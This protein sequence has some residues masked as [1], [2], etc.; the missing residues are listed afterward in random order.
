MTSAERMAK[1]L[2]LLQR[3]V[4]GESLTD[5]GNEL[6]ITKQA[7]SR[8]FQRFLGDEEYAIVSAQIRTRL[9]A[10]E[11]GTRTSLFE[12]YNQTAAILWTDEQM[13]E[14]LR[15]FQRTYG[16]P[17]TISRIAKLPPKD[18]HRV[19]TPPIYYRRFGTWIEACRRAGVTNGKPSRTN[20]KRRWNEDEIVELLIPFA[21]HY[22][23]RGLRPTSYRYTEWHARW[24]DV[25]PSLATIRNR[26]LWNRFMGI[27]LTRLREEQGE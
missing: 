7:V 24:A 6:G 26:G 4:N 15:W 8:R 20:Y 12:P 16:P 13:L 27:V 9:H 25:T 14:A 19:P 5:L 23:E 1:T 3:H 18:R 2:R 22:L 10:A 11:P 21:R 17:V